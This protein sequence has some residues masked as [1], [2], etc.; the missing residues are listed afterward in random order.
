MNFSKL[1]ACLVVTIQISSILMAPPRNVVE[2]KEIMKD[3]EKIEKTDL[4]VDE[5]KPVDHLD[6]V[7]L[8]QDGMINKDYKKEIFLGNHEEI[9]DDSL[10]VAE[11]KLKDIFAKI[12][13]DSDSKLCF[14]EV[15][16]W[17]LEKT[18]EHFDEA[19]QENDHIF[20]HMDPDGDGLVDWKEYYLHF[21]LAKGYKPEKASKHVVDYDDIDLDYEEREQLIRYKFKWTDADTDPMDNKLS[22]T[23][24]LAFRHPEQSE[25]ALNN[26]V[27]TIM[28]S[29]DKDGDSYL[30]EEEFVTLPLGDA[31]DEEQIKLDKEWQKERS[32]EFRNQIDFDHN[33]K[34]S[35]DELKK[36][37]DP[38]NPENAKSDTRTLLEEMDDNEDGCISWEEIDTHR[39]MFIQSKLVNMPRILHDEF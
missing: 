29:L 6:A 36:Y 9:E 26:M 33:G 2:M 11:S 35:M 39:D 31:E 10:D 20:E 21:L 22:K 14:G 8:E 7:K 27:K 37:I 38:R 19:L 15:E 17:I 13:K 4:T 16:G 5:L 18:Q 12:D 23:E 30:T 3:M 32:T 34:V 28:E 24:F 25:Q 1:L